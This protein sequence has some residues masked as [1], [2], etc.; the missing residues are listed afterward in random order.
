MYQI[1]ITKFTQVLLIFKDFLRFC[2]M[3]YLLDMLSKN[4]NDLYRANLCYSTFLLNLSY[5]HYK[6]KFHYFLNLDITK[7]NFFNLNK[8]AREEIKNKVKQQEEMFDF[9]ASREDKF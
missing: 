9:E 3:K 2:S 8:D 1:I 4:L 5:Q 6:F 7:Y